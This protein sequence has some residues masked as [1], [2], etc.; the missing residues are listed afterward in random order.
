MVDITQQET[1]E[2]LLFG[3]D[4]VYTEQESSDSSDTDSKVENEK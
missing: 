3:V 4:G 2:Q 1:L